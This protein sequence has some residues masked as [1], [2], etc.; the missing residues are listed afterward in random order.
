M[1]WIDREECVRALLS[2]RREWRRRQATVAETRAAYVAARK[3]AKLSADRVEVAL[4]SLEAR[5]AT[6]DFDRSTSP[7]TSGRH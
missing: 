3:A 1:S 5:Q 6:F 7:A 2:A 4:A